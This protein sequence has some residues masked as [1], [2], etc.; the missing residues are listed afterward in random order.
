MSHLYRRTCTYVQPAFSTKESQ[1]PKTHPHILLDAEDWDN[2]IERNK[3]NPEAQ[4]YIRKANTCLNHPLKHLGEEIDTTQV[5]KLTDIVQYRSAL[6]WES[7]KIVDREE[8]NI[9]AMVRAYLLTKDEVYYKESIKRLSEILSWKNSK[10]FA[11]D[12]NRS[13]ILSMNTS[14]YDTWYNLRTSNEKNCS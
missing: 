10:Y 13:T 14:A 12:F 5:V 8:A 9:E 1:L 3:N 4:A 6:I 11:G 7:R 2:I